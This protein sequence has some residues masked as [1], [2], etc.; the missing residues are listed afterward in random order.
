MNAI[1]KNRSQW[2]NSHD[3]FLMVVADNLTTVAN[4]IVNICLF[5]E[6]NVTALRK[7]LKKADKQLS[8]ICLPL[9][10]KF[11]N[12]ALEQPGSLLLHFLS[13]K[14]VYESYLIL[15]D[16]HKVLKKIISQRAASDSTRRSLLQKQRDNRVSVEMNLGSYQDLHKPLL[17]DNTS[18][19]GG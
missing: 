9:G 3:H 11:L 1:L 12:N 10:K 8:S 17:K 4:K 5:V 2:K 6:L 16:C 7:I 14:M 15:E 18:G 19:S 13:H